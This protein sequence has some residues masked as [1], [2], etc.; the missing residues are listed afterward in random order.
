M[1]YVM[2]IETKQSLQYLQNAG[3]CDCVK[4][5]GKE[6]KNLRGIG[7]MCMSLVLCTGC[8]GKTREEVKEQ[9]AYDEFQEW[10][11]EEQSDQ[12][13]ENMLAILTQYSDEMFWMK[14]YDNEEDGINVERMIGQNFAVR[15]RKDE[16]RGYFEGSVE[17][18]EANLCIVNFE[19]MEYVIVEENLKSFTLGDY[20]VSCL[21]KEDV[22]GGR[23][24]EL[25]VFYCPV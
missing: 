18:E 24:V 8:A 6:M 14:L 5:K 22:D 10:L 25:L 16:I 21:F 2:Y 13:G 3:L 11:A 15:G 9:V 19:T 7:L 1:K 20:Y 4:R 17:W 23:Q 12:V